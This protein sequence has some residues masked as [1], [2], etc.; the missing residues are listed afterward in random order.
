MCVPE[1][2][3]PSS[4]LYRVKEK[5]ETELFLLRLSFVVDRLLKDGAGPTLALLRVLLK[6][7]IIVR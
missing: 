6:F 7:I 4:G 5:L 2:P 3:A 1:K